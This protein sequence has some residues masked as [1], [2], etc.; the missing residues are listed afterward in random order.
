M[1]AC[2]TTTG[3]VQRFNQLLGVL[4]FSFFSVQQVANAAPVVI[5]VDHRVT[6]T[7]SKVQFD[8]GKGVYSTQARIKNR[9]AA[10]LYSPLRLSFDQAALKNIRLLNAHGIGKD[11]Q[12]YFEF[13]LS[14]E[15]LLTKSETK[16][17]KVVFAVEKDKRAAKGGDPKGVL[18]ILAAAQRVSAGT[19]SAL[20]KPNASPSDL[21]ANSGKKTVRFSVPLLG[22]AKP[23][24]T[25][26][27]RRSGDKKS[28][29][30]NDLGK[31]GDVT[32]KDGILGVNVQI[33]TAKVKPDSCLHYEAFI[34]QDRA[35]L[36]SPALRLCVSSFPVKLAESNIANPAVF[37]DGSKAVADE[38]LLTVTPTTTA[39]AIR[40]LARSIN[41]NVVGS[42]LSL[43]LYQLKLPSPVNVN[44][45]LE[46][47][48]QLRARA[49]VVSASINAIGQFALNVDD[50]AFDLLPSDINSQHGLKLVLAHNEA[51]NAN[52][53]DTG[54]TGNGVTVIVLDSGLD[55]THDDFG[56]PGSCQLVDNDCGP[57]GFNND[58]NGHGTQVA[59]VVAAKTNNT[60]GV[61]GVAFG[62]KIHAIQVSTNTNVVASQMITGFGLVRDY[63]AVHPEASVVNASFFAAGGSAT[64]AEWASVC[65]AIDQVVLNGVTPRAVVVNAVGNNNLNGV[66]YPARCNDL[67]PAL[68]RK[69]LLITVSNSASVVTAACGSVA[70]DQRCSTSNYGAWVDI[71]APG[72]SIRTTTIGNTY[73]NP[74]GNSFSA[75]LVAGAAAILRSCSVP[76]P[77]D[78]IQSTLTTSA[79]V[80][81][82]YPAFGGN[83]A[84]N[85][86]RLDIHRALS[87]QAPTGVGLSNNSINENNAAGAPV[88]TLTVTDPDIC[89]KFT[90][91]LVAGAGD[92]DNGAFTITGDQL[93]INGVANYEA[94]TSYSIRVRVTDFGGA[95]FDQTLTVNVNDV[96]EFDVGAVTDSNA[97]AN[98]VAENAVNGTAVGLTATA[99]DADGSNNTITYSLTNSAGG[100]FAINSNSGVVSVAGAIDREAAASYNIT[101]RATSADSSFSDQIFTINV[102]DVDE[103]DVGAVTDSNAAANSV[104]ENAVNGTTVALTASASDADATTNTITYSL[105]DNAGGRFA[106]NTNSGVASVANGLLLDYETAISHSVTV[107][108]SSSDGSTSNQSFTV[109]ITNANDNPPVITSNGGGAAAAIN[110]AENITAV[111]TVTATDADAGSTFTYGLAGVDSARFAISSTGVLNFVAAPNFEMPTDAGGNNVY[112]VIVQVSDGLNTDT[113]AIAVTVTNV[114][115][116]PTGNPSITGTRTVG[117]TLTADLT[118]IANPDGWSVSAYQWRRSGGDITLNGNGSSY[119]LVLDDYQEYMSVCVT[120]TSVT[121]CSGT[122]A[123]AVGDPHMTTVDGLHYDFQGAGEFVALR[124]TDG[125]EIQLRQ[126]AVSTAGPLTDGYSG[127]SVGVSINTAV[128]ARAG[129][130]RVTF[131]PNISGNPASGGLELR[132]DGVVKMLPAD[133]LDLGSGGRVIS[134]PGGG[135]QIDFPDQTTLI[136]TPGW[137]APHNVWYLNVSALHTSAY[138]GLMGA[139]T[140]GSWLPRLANGSS[141]G[142]RPAALPDRYAELYVKFADS[143]RVN[144]KSSLFDYAKDTSTRTF[145][146]KEWPKENPP[147]TVGQGPVAKPAKRAVAQRAC[148]EVVGKNN[149]ADCVFD[150]MATGNTGFAKTYLLSQKIVAGLTSITVRDDKDPSKLQEQV[151]FTATVTRNATVKQTAARGKGVPTGTVQFTLN[152]ERV[153]KPVKL[154]AKGQARWKVSSL[155]AGKS[156]I[157]ARYIPAKGSVFLPSVSLDEPHLVE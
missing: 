15:M 134:A 148:R 28:I 145:T 12:P 136:V 79:N 1:N 58:T 121:L 144:D 6:V 107:L 41:A 3:L 51:T 135:I 142:S 127:L 7:Y 150:V 43:N 75:P 11:G 113:Q 34:K 56:V 140:Q 98:N 63:V 30:M 126:T 96:D 80:V 16:P 66:I 52:A 88:A 67:N 21:P 105:T 124:G 60:L 106:I 48:A 115:E 47:A 46:I 108:A 114:S 78:Q 112:D 152:G 24:A 35:E 138:D 27:L 81:V 141:L 49:G 109:T 44:Q 13:T 125:M 132:V 26:Y 39:A 70:I 69:D 139:R 42:Y 101:V 57:A 118:L 54:A 95:T 25:V 59:G 157:A 61:A 65:G 76:V 10:A 151:T 129:A 83:P 32:A 5:S 92:A 14:K 110:V 155:R 130:H 104:A 131:Q 74:T 93:A 102:N 53:W 19:E 120:Y 33:D 29:A 146:L 86:P 84:G 123:V 4:V 90:F 85:T 116:A 128:A 9:S 91:A 153:G 50:T 40:Q 156:R 94:K 89:D 117:Q 99:S 82:P 103:F 111:T 143:W 73:A 55:H 119:D 154:D 38:I 8:A 87:Y 71:A 68:T 36:L 137:W 77:L 64:A 100:R 72:S 31:D 133:G 17:V 22:K 2:L 20:L 122:D 23:S 62:S 37:P 18:S 97:A 149:K 45:L 147:Y